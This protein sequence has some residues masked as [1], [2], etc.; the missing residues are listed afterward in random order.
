MLPVL[1]T[2]A[3]AGVS[4]TIGGS[5]RLHRLSV[6]CDEVSVAILYVSAGVPAIQAAWN[7]AAGRTGIP[8]P[9]ARLLPAPP[10]QRPARSSAG[11]WPSSR[12]SRQSGSGGQLR[13]HVVLFQTASSH[14]APARW[15]T[16]LPR[17]ALW[18]VHAAW[19]WHTR[20]RRAMTGCPHAVSLLANQEELGP[21][22]AA[23]VAH[24][25]RAAISHAFPAMQTYARKGVSSASLYANLAQTYAACSGRKSRRS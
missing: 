20:Q 16:H 22:F 6:M 25:T 8:R 21:T 14:R 19:S 4:P 5:C 3:R 2:A 23:W 7:F 24:P 17:E 11:N 18:S 12:C 10:V 15:K 9:T 13:P 1:A